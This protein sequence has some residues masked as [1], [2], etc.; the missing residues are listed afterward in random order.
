[1][2]P[3]SAALEIEQH[4]GVPAGPP[5]ATGDA[6]N[7]ILLHTKQVT[8]VG[9]VDGIPVEA[10]D[11]RSREI[12]LDTD[13]PS[14]QAARAFTDPKLVVAAYLTAENTPAGIDSAR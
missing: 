10:I 1:M 5:D 3:G 14:P 13:H 8:G 4:L 9:R 11:V 2:S 6:R 12:T 7:P